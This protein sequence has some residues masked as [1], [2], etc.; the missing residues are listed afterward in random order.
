MVVEV[1]QVSDDQKQALVNA[2]K[3]CLL[4]HPVMSRRHPSVSLRVQNY[5]KNLRYARK[6]A[7]NLCMSEKFCN[8]ASKLKDYAN[9][10][11]H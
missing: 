2:L 10:Q 8:F 3:L 4:P 7:K 9:H 1:S 11:T 6:L 5:Y